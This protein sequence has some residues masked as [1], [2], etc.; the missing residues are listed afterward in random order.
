MEAQTVK[1]RLIRI[2]NT[3]QGERLIRDLRRK[4]N[5]TI[6]EYLGDDGE[7][8]RKIFYCYETPFVPEEGTHENL[9]AIKE[10]W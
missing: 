5:S 10:Q 2:V 8:Y 6:A 9:K 4:P 1:L 3:S 7:I